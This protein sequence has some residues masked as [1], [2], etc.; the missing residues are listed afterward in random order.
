VVFDGVALI[1]AGGR[2]E[3]FWPLSRERFPKQFLSI[4]GQNTMIQETVKRVSPL[5]GMENTYVLTG[6]VYESRVRSLLS[7]L[8]PENIIIEPEGRDT[9]PCVALAS[10][11]IAGAME[12]KA[13]RR[14]AGKQPRFTKESLT[15]DDDW[16]DPVMIVLPS[17]H[18]IADVPRFQETL[19]AAV[20]VASHT[21]GLVTIGITP[22]RPE[23][24]YGYIECG[25]EAESLA[26]GSSIR[27]REVLRF[28]E[29]PDLQTAQQFLA[30]RRFLWNSGMFIWRLSVFG[31]ALK[32]H[33][34]AVYYAVQRLVTV[35]NTPF[36]AEAL[37]REYSRLPKISLDYGIL[38]KETDIYV[39]PGDFGW[40]DVG[41]WSSLARLHPMDDGGNVVHT[42]PR[43]RKR[44]HARSSPVL[45]DTKDCI[46]CSTGRLVAAVGVED[47]IVVETDDAVLVCKKGDDQRIKEV[48][49]K[50]KQAGMADYL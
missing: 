36:G 33:L 20:D 10:V 24:G 27:P 4:N 37:A 7:D 5:V 47:V 21:D 8:P 39:V 50:L 41:S 38:E 14:H 45:V 16:A 42:W 46:V 23:T 40:D 28:R 19:R 11:Y 43:P 1:M 31:R 29:K 18:Y 9:A 26:A 35:L 49:T 15:A 48:V 12:Q 34:P 44:G 32:K 6:K 3:R 30:S 22:T 25:K 2:G 13:V 17:D